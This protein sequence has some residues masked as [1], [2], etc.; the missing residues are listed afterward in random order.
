MSSRTLSSDQW[1][2]QPSSEKAL[3]K[4]K[5]LKNTEIHNRPG[6]REYETAETSNSK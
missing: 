3:L 4:V 2:S 1:I 6:Y 5:K